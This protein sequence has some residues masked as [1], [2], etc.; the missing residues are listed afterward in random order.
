MLDSGSTNIFCSE[1]L[2]NELHLTGRHVS[3][4]VSTVDQVK[5]PVHVRVVNFK[6]MD[7]K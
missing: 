7:V 4:H 2:A 3:I 6:L 5:T 1:E